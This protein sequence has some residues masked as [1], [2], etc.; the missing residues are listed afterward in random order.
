[1]DRRAWQAMVP[2]AAERDMT[3]AAKHACM[4]FFFNSLSDVYLC[5]LVLG[6]F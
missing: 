4:Q 1:M 5:I 3:E 2:R 6:Q